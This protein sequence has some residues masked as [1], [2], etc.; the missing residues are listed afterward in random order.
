MTLGGALK[1]EIQF[2]GGR[3]LNGK[4]SKYPVPRFKDVP[5]IESVFLNRPDLPSTGAGE[6]PM[7]A[8]PP[9][10]ANAVY[11]ACSV[12]VRSMPIRGAA[13]QRA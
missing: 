12:R 7:I 13:L 2:E 10:L 9:A 11:H 5:A 6:T 3:L 8:V 4:F 1:E